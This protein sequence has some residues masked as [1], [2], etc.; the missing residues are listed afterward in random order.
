MTPAFKLVV[1]N[2]YNRNRKGAIDT[3]LTYI[4][5]VAELAVSCMNASYESK[6]AQEVQEYVD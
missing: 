2:F 6:D 4:V 3:Q 5:E 1:A